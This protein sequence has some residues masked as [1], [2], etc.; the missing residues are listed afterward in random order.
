M[1][2]ARPRQ[3]AFVL[4]TSVLL[5]GLDRAHSQSANWYEIRQNHDRDGSGKFSMGRE[6][7]QVMGH[8]AAD[9]LERPERE[10]EEQPELALPALKIKPGD[11][12]ADIGAGSGY[13][14]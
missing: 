11:A 14:T 1:H 6:I 13:Y 3:F 12:V 8:Q 9:W 4:L 10:N 2:F 7:A 5:S